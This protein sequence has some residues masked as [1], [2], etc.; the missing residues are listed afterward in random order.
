MTALVIGARVH[1]TD[2][3]EIAEIDVHTALRELL[4]RSGQDK[5]RVEVWREGDTNSPVLTSGRSA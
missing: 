1:L 3:G 2:D 4:N 5:A